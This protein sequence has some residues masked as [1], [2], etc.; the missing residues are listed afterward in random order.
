[1]TVTAR[2]LFLDRRLRVQDSAE[3]RY[4]VE[5]QAHVAPS[6]DHDTAVG[7]LGLDADRIEGWSAV[8]ARVLD[9]ASGLSVVPTELAALGVDVDAVDAE[10]DEGHPELARAA[11]AVRS[12]YPAQMERLEQLL[13]SPRYELSERHLRL[14]RRSLERRL[15]VARAYPGGPK[16]RLLVDATDLAPISDGSYDVVLCGWLFVHLDESSQ[17]RATQ[18]LLRVTRPGGE[19]R[20]KAG[21]GGDARRELP[22]LPPDWTLDPESRGDLLVLRR[23]ALRID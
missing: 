4:D 13:G 18:S 8:G 11:S 15:E 19:V 1:M 23:A 5:R 9:V 6:W 10:F 3:T 17:A 2:G 7:G 14:F 12:L 21:H 22:E 20:I 16:R